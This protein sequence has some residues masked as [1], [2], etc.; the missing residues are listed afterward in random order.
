MKLPLYSA[1]GRKQTSSA[2]AVAIFAEPKNQTLLKLAYHYTQALRRVNLAKTKTRSQVRGSSRKHHIQKRTGRARAGTKQSPIRRGG[3]VAFG[4]TGAENYQ[5]KL[6]KKARLLALKQALQVKK[7]QI[8]IVQQLPADGKTKTLAQLLKTLSLQ[9]RILLVSD[10][11]T[12]AEYLATRNLPDVN[13]IAQ[14]SL[15]VKRILDANWIVFTTGGL[16]NLEARLK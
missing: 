9:K 1:T 12:P 15:N 10:Q 14:T 16:A 11:I 7:E 2:E 13:L 8:I 4:P 6:N 3:G 5:L